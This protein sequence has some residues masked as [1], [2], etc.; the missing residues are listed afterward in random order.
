MK[1]LVTGIGGPAGKSTAT[2]FLNKGDYVIGTDIR[3]VDTNVNEF[4]LVPPAL[5]R[6]FMD[7]ILGIIQKKG[8]DVF[9]PTVT[10]ELPAVSQNRLRIRSL[11]AQLFIPHPQVVKIVNNKYLTA[12]KLRELG[13]PSPKTFMPEDGLNPI[14]AGEIL[15]YPFV[16]KP[17]YG[18]GGRGLMVYHSPEEALN[19]TRTDIVFQEFI[20]GQE[21]D[22]NLFVFPA[23]RVKSV[24]VLKKTELKGGIV[25]NAL[26]VERVQKDGDVKDLAI[27]AAEKLNLEGP[28]DMDIRR[29]QKNEP[30]IL[31]INARVGANVLEAKE[32]LEEF[33]KTLKQEELK[34]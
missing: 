24:V 30:I 21:Y 34:C 3:K 15:G 9:V 7:T 6:E 28:I 17:V 13:L 5:S 26:K 12:M 23:G 18:R 22:V 31:E 29:N 16:V 2:F 8:V 10:E 4:L 19:E 14:S 32:I 20:S 33:Y 11:G 27:S 25:G 1:I